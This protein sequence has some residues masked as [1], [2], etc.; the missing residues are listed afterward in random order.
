MLME[1]VE[2]RTE[3][4]ATSADW[5]EVKHLTGHVGIDLVNLGVEVENMHPLRPLA[6]NDGTNL[7][8][9]EPQLPRID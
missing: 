8:L 9:E 5:I 1:P 6:F 3:I 7:R 4:G 2:A